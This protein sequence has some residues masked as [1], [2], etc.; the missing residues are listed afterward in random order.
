LIRELRISPAAIEELQIS[1]VKNGCLHVAGRARPLSPECETAVWEAIGDRT[2]GPLFLNQTGHCAYS[3]EALSA[4][5]RRLA[6]KAGLPPEAKLL[7]GT[8]ACRKLREKK[9]KTPRR[10]ETQAEAMAALA[11]IGPNLPAIAKQI[12][13]SPQRLYRWKDFMHAYRL[14][15]QGSTS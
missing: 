11:V 10:V 2:E 1:D 15:K 5:F 4:A 7:G 12:G 3:H 6:R 13:I 14:Q 8:A 9:S